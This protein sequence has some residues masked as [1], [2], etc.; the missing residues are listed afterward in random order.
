[1]IANARSALSTTAEPR[2]LSRRAG[3]LQI[4]ALAAI[5][6]LGVGSL[7]YMSVFSRNQDA[8]NSVR[9]L[10]ECSVAFDNVVETLRSTTFSEIYASYQRATFKTQGLS[11]P[12]GG[13]AS[14]DVTFHVDE[15]RIPAAFG[16]VSDLDGKPYQVS[17]DCS[18]SYQ[19]LPAELKLEYA[20]SRG[21]EVR[22]MYIL[23]GPR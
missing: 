13:P 14:V 9:E 7:G 4:E 3:A 22:R 10:D 1:M 8:L 19:L 6:L 16:E 11:A 18:S 5:T 21:A 17:A 12:T 20:T 2:Q 23:L 15:G